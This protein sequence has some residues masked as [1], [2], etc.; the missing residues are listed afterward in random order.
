MYWIIGDHDT[1]LSFRLAGVC[2][3]VV[4]SDDEALSAFERALQKSD[5]QVL[6]V[7]DG[8]AKAISEAIVAH[9]LAAC[10]PY[11]T[12]IPG[13]TGQP[14]GWTDLDALISEAVGMKVS[15]K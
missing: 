4:T 13:M 7:T 9:R 6:I 2:G 14:N 1:V 3:D 8:V 5:L 12:V 15:Q 10:A 11:V